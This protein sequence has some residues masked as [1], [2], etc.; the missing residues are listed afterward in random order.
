MATQKHA[1]HATSL[2]NPENTL[3]NETR[4]LSPLSLAY[5]IEI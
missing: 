5:Q 4:Y 1:S 2:E 3:Q